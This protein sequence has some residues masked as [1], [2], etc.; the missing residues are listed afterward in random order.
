MKEYQELATR[1]LAQEKLPTTYCAKLF[2]VHGTFYRR[3]PPHAYTYRSRLE[4]VLDGAKHTLESMP[5]VPNPDA[6]VVMMNPGSSLARD[7][8]GTEILNQDLPVVRDVAD[9]LRLPLVRAR[10]D[11]TQYQIMRLM[12]LRDWTHVRVIN[13]S[14]YRS[15][16]SSD[17]YSHLKSGDLFENHSIFSGQ[18]AAEFDSCI[19]KKKIC[20][21][22]WGKG[23]EDGDAFSSL[24][25][26]ALLAISGRWAGLQ[27]VA[28]RGPDDSLW[29]AT[30]PLRPS[31][32]L[33]IKWLKDVNGLLNIKR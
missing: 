3:P 2:S 19:C 9:I 22:A 7:V 27:V 33:Q 4:I 28:S 29:M 26:S 16:S 15:K 31:N 1:M 20:V 8:N 32:T 14:D 21:L 25:K 12:L 30:H 11:T 18:R 6:I 23:E 13:L 5:C 17:Y 10:P 24:A